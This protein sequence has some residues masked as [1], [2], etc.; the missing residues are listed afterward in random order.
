MKNKV[1]KIAYTSGW[2]YR[3]FGWLERLPIP[4]WRSAY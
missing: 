3:F 1:K 2:L 4:L